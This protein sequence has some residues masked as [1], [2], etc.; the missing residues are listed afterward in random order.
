M[1]VDCNKF[2]EKLDSLQCTKRLWSKHE[3]EFQNH[4]DVLIVA[5]GEEEDKMVNTVEVFPP[6]PESSCLP[7]LPKA[8][9][10][11]AMGMLGE[12]LLLCGG[13]NEAEQPSQACWTLDNK[14][15]QWKP[16]NNL[17]RYLSNYKI[18]KIGENYTF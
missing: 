15:A 11:G 1:S 9:K 4:P 10:W 16:Q 13:Q 17:T 14:T 2:P 7:N 6:S 5:G 12:T 8:L 18:S 3:T